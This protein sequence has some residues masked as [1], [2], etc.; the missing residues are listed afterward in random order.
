MTAYH[1]LIDTLFS[2]NRSSKKK[3]NLKEIK[4][5]AA[6]LGNPHERYPT[7]HIAGTNGK[8]SVLC[9]IGEALRLSGYRV[10]LF[11]SPHIFSYRERI[12]VDREMIGKNE[13]IEGLKLLFQL[14]KEKEISP[15]FFELT[16]L[17][18]FDYFA[19]KKVDIALIE[20]GIGGRLDPTNVIRPILSIITTIDFDHQDILG[21]TLEEIAR[22]KGGIIKSQTPVIIGPHTSQEIL[23]EIARKKQAPLY[24]AQSAEDENQAIALKS[25]ELLNTHFSIPQKARLAGIEKQPRCRFELFGERIVID[26]AHNRSAFDRLFKQLGRHFPGKSIFLLFSC[27]KNKDFSSF[28]SLFCQYVSEIGLFETSHSRLKDP[29]EIQRELTAKGYQNWRVFPTIS[30]AFQTLLKKAKKKEG[31]L[32]IGGSFYLIDLL[33]PTLSHMHDLSFRDSG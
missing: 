33:K 1:A 20:T 30:I 29:E 15:T 12:L 28:S 13:V 9:K 19:K 27:S 32:L 10:G 18:A 2:L 11:S 16:T 23:S 21:E 5:L 25:L 14:A 17:L 26:V 3:K 24:T 31:V 7:V 8:G 6:M 4:A 22:E